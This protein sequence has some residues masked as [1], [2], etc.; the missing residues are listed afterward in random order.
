MKT[1]VW[2]R[3]SLLMGVLLLLTSCVPQ[4]VTGVPN[5]D[6]VF[7]TMYTGNETATLGFIDADGSNLTH[8]EFRLSGAMP[9]LPTWTPDGEYLLFRKLYQIR[10]VGDLFAITSD[11]RVKAYETE[12]AF[13]DDAAAVTKDGRY[14]VVHEAGD[15]NGKEHLYLLNLSSG[16]VE[17]TYVTGVMEGYVEC[18]T[19][20]LHGSKLV[21]VY[22]ELINNETH[23]ELVLRDLDAGAET[24]LVSGRMIIKPAIS[25]DGRWIA[26][27]TEDG[28]HIVSTD[29]SEN[30]QIVA[31]A[32]LRMTGTGFTWDYSPPVPSW[33]PDSQWIV[34]HRCTLPG[35]QWCNE[36]SHYSIFKA[37][38]ETGEE[39]FL[40]EQGL[41]PYWRL[42]EE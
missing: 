14:A 33:S 2:F 3:I 11:G 24:I 34:Y 1:G 8:I 5:A 13:G 20:A 15:P 31:T 37:N 23:G 26:Y 30:H 21:Y 22:Q 40:V 27:T 32:V 19:N 36:L 18:G 7:Q 16:K 10:H 12:L 9:A 42:K 41:N 39:V 29:G 17:Q 28:I 25:P 4:R 6:I 38:I 35:K